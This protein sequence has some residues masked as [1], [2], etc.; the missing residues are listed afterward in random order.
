MKLDFAIPQD[1]KIHEYCLDHHHETIEHHW[2]KNR[3]YYHCLTCQKDYT[4]RIKIDPTITSFTAEDGEYWHKS[5]GIFVRNPD[6]KFL[7]YT[8]KTFPYVVTIPSGHVDAGEQVLAAAQRE[9]KEEVDLEGSLLHISDEAILEDPCS[10]GSDAHFWHV[11][12]L[13]V[14][15]TPLIRIAKAEGMRPKWLT[16]D[17]A[18]KKNLTAPVSYLI[19]RHCE[20]LN[21]R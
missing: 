8:R 19:E 16:L 6:N 2:H 4:R 20:R 17:L 3:K 11:Y 1:G 12:L 7:F 13:T 14:D 5:V 21:T 18:L 9:L 15:P 10:M